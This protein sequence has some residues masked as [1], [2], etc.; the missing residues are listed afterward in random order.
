MILQITTNHTTDTTQSGPASPAES[1]IHT[2]N[3]RS[4][5]LLYQE[6]P[7]SLVTSDVP[8]YFSFSFY[9]GLTHGSPSLLPATQGSSLSLQ[10]PV[11]VSLK[12]KQKLKYVKWKKILKIFCQDWKL[13]TNM[14][15][16]ATEVETAYA[17]VELLQKRVNGLEIKT[18]KKILNRTPCLQAIAYC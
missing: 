7:N 13:K 8:S 4:H 9:L 2:A 1:Y 15:L 12:R 5:V 3:L 18:K 17:T 10:T 6:A 11:L 14:E 16:L